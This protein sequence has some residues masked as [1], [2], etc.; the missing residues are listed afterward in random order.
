MSLE[1]TNGF[2]AFGGGLHVRGICTA[3]DWHSLM[4]FW[5]GDDALHRIYTSISQ[6]DLPF[7]EDAL[8]DQFFLRGEECY[9]L[10]AEVDD[11]EALGCDFEG[12]I[13]RAL[14]DPVEF[15]GLEPLIQFRREGGT[16]NPGDLLNAYPPFSTKE[17]ANGVQLAAVP[18]NE[19]HYF[20]AQLVTQLRGQPDQSRFRIR[21]E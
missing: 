10:V 2:V 21:F 13:S 6:E 7:G 4:R 18:A 12:F 3:P 14:A 17:A 11:I 9:R 1:E 16:L 20:L 19:Q 5:S 8:G 15:L